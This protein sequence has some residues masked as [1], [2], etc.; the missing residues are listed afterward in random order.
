MTH[1]ETNE[2]AN[3][4]YMTRSVVSEISHKLNEN[5]SVNRE[6]I[7]A[8]DLIS[9]DLTID[10]NNEND[11]AKLNDK[12]I[13]KIHDNNEIATP[14][15]E[16]SKFDTT[17]WDRKF[18][19]VDELPEIEIEENESPFSDKYGK[20]K[21][22]NNAL[23]WHVRMGHASVSYLKELQKQFADCKELNK[24]IF[25]DSIV[26]C[27]VCKIAKFNKLPFQNTRQWATEPLQIIHSDIMGK[28]SPASY[29]KGYK[30]ISVFI[31]D[32]SRLA[33]AYPMKT[34]DETGYCLEAYVRSARNLLG[35]DA[36]V[37]YLRTDQETEYVCGYTDKVLNNLGAEQQLACPDTPEHNGVAERFNQT[38][39][40]K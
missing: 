29:P 30:Y 28:I 34:K 19:D 37:C 23:L 18:H 35:R 38:I 8:N 32:Y 2:I 40:K 31:D 26:D 9:N 3:P 5:E 4:R 7:E 11:T 39:Q 1:N 36:K 15:Y 6:T 16:F 22:N 10:K 27:Y 13:K 25:D 24:A 20:F 12:G 17:I 33:M 21:K 14:V